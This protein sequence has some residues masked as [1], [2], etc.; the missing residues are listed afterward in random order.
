MRAV[1]DASVWVDAILDGPRR[2]PALL[3][4]ENLDPWAPQLIDSE[5]VS[6][7]ARLERAGVI[8]SHES[9]AA[10]ADWRS[11]RIERA[12]NDLLLDDVWS[13]RKSI[14]T[15]DAFYVVLARILACPLITSD[16][17]LSRGPLGDVTVT[18]VR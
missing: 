5:V 18:L 9:D 8:S 10:M 15:T 14:R 17:R 4:V 7:V 13:L 2:D 1:V 12:S 16:A 3:A 11:V 6:A